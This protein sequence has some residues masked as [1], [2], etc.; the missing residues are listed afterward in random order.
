MPKSI[1]RE[2]V[3]RM[4]RAGAQLVEVLPSPEY[5][6]DHLPGAIH[7]A[8]RHI[9]DQGVEKLDRNRPVIVY[10]WDTA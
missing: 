5:E 2:E 9:E 8:L 1:D 10:C 3:Q 6:E 4:V 7:L